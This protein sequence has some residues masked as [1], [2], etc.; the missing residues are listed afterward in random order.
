VNTK[1]H[2]GVTPLMSATIKGIFECVQILVDVGAEINTVAKD[3]FTALMFGAYYG[4][5]EIVKY[6]LTQGADKKLATKNNET[7][8]S[9]AKK[10]KFNEIATILG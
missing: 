7:A 10:K 5:T 3:G 8:F 2:K 1:N 9:I 6:L 4:N